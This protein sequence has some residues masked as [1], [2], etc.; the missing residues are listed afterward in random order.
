MSRTSKSRG[1]APFQMRSG[2]RPSPHK[3]L[4]KLV[5][6]ASNVA[7]KIFGGGG[8]GAEAAPVDNYG[9]PNRGMENPANP[10]NKLRGMGGFGGGMMGG[11]M[12]GGPS[13][14]AKKEQGYTPYKKVGFSCPSPLKGADAVLVRG[15]YDAESGKG[16]AKYGQIAK[17]R[18]FTSIAKTSGQTFG[19]LAAQHKMKK[20]AERKASLS[21]KKQQWKKD[22]KF[23]KWKE[24]KGKGWKDNMRYA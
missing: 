21:Y 10:S 24:R 20:E 19:Y 23:E 14:M 17:S 13:A 22:A 7:S 6:G 8:G 4:G 15:A 5:K 12:L 1:S 9:R 16:T 18:A 3:F 2:N 11:N